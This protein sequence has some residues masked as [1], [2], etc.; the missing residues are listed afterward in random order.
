MAAKKVNRK[1]KTQ[2]YPSHHAHLK[3]KRPG[4]KGKPAGE[5]SD[6]MRL[7]IDHYFLHNCRSKGD[8]MEAGGYSRKDGGRFFSMPQVVDEMARRQAELRER[9]NLT[10]DWVIKRLMD[11]ADGNFG[12]ILVKLKNNGWDLSSLTMEERYV[13]GEYSEEGVMMGRGEA[14]VEGLKRKIKSR[15]PMP[16]LIALSRKLG[17]FQDKVHITGAEALVERL[18]KGRELAA[19]RAKGEGGS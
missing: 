18:Q 12:D 9:Y 15:D 11:V 3:P 6:K 17:L 10:E 4:K 1:T 7:V 2:D 8:A 14:A 19:A 13:L 16:A 5:L